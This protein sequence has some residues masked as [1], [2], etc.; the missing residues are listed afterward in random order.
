MMPP[1]P[2]KDSMRGIELFDPMLE[3]GEYTPGM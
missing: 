3:R 1:P 2:R